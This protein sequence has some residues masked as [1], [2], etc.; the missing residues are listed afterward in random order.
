MRSKAGIDQKADK[1]NSKAV[2][3]SCCRIIYINLQIA[4][5][6][7]I[8]EISRYLNGYKFTN[9][10]CLSERVKNVFKE[11]STSPVQFHLELAFP[12]RGLKVIHKHLK[13]SRIYLNSTKIILH[14]NR[15]REIIRSRCYTRIAILTCGR[16][17]H[18]ASYY[19]DPVCPI[20]IISLW[21]PVPAVR[22]S[23]V[24]GKNVKPFGI[25]K[26]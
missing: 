24:A 14:I 1:I 21:F 20:R 18:I 9:G 13:H 7:Y 4:T 11:W 23:R 8:Q 12:N 19:H 15:L 26:A 16:T 5:L 25:T 2:S 17:A 6:N 22:R 3:C 10:S